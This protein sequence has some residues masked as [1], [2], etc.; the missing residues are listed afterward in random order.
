MWIKFQVVGIVEARHGNRAEWVQMQNT[1]AEWGVVHYVI[2]ICA[3]VT[4]Q[5]IVSTSLLSFN[6]FSRYNNNKTLTYLYI[7]PNHLLF[8]E[9]KCVDLVSNLSGHEFTMCL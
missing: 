7:N 2:N 6:P 4:V 5:E 8:T 9:T 3:F 1:E